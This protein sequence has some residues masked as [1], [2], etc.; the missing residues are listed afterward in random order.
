MSHYLNIISLSNGLKSS[1]PLHPFTVEQKKWEIAQ[2]H[3][4]HWQFVLNSSQIWTSCPYRIGQSRILLMA[5]CRKDFG[6]EVSLT[7][8]GWKNY[9]VDQIDTFRILSKSG[10]FLSLFSVYNDSTPHV[11]NIILL[12]K[13]IH[14]RWRHSIVTV[15]HTAIMSSFEYVGISFYGSLV[16]FNQNPILWEKWE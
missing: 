4:N 3:S 13:V 11:S 10:H 14:S 6:D 15:S 5:I 16:S 7:M 9:L 12:L 8:L 1:Y 2:S